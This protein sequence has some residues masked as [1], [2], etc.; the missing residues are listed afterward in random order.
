M[1]IDFKAPI[2]TLQNAHLTFGL[3]PL[4]QGLDLFINYGDKI[5]LIG[6]NGSGKSTLMKVIAGL[7]EID[8]GKIFTQ[9]GIKISY[10]AQESDFKGF[11]S[12]KE[13]ILSG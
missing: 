5:C 7:L 12:L 9:P 4:F 10:M 8:D 13:I 1:A 11:S 3:H 2:Y 6:R